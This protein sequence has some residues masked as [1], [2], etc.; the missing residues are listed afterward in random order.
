MS[1]YE[2]DIIFRPGKKN[3]NA[4]ALSRLPLKIEPRSTPIPCEVVHLMD[5][6]SR[7]CSE[8]QT[9]D[10][11]SPGVSTSVPNHAWI[12]NHRARGQNQVIFYSQKRIECPGR[13]YVMGIES[14][15]T[16]SDSSRRKSGHRY[17]ARDTSWYVK[18]R[19]YVW[20]PGMDKANEERARSYSTPWHI[21]QK[22][23]PRASEHPWEWPHQPWYTVHVDYAS[24]PAF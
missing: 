4:D 12:A 22:V 19:G 17:P 20:W 9:M 8:N 7:R 10:N 23:P 5:Q 2:Y 13:L 15:D 24:P 3:S 18:T 1:A 6:L 14:G 11:E 16:S 21:H